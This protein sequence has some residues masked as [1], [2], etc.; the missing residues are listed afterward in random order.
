MSTLLHIASFQIYFQSMLSDGINMDEE[1]A[2]GGE[3]EVERMPVRMIEPRSK[4]LVPVFDG[5]Q[6]PKFHQGRYVRIFLVTLL[7][8]QYLLSEI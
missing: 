7:I 4:E 8:V 6:A 3:I 5:L 1:G 2:F